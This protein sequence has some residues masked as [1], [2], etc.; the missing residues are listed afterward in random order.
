MTG[1][2]LLVLAI[3]GERLVELVVSTRHAA[4]LRGEGGVE[5]GRG[6][7]P[8]MVVLHIALLVGCFVEPTVADRPF[9]PL[10]GWPMVLVVV[11][12]MG[13]RWWCI[14]TLGH[15][16]N[17]RVIV[18]PSLPLVTG[19]PYRFLRHPNYVAVVAEGAAL[20]LI[21]TAWITAIGF[22]VLNAVLLTVRIRVENRALATA[23]A[24]RPASSADARA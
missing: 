8:L 5:Y 6:H 17:T 9:I 14:G 16:W 20:P 13:L 18:A 15:H 4:F 24:G 1:Y 3:A 23:T 21:H 10:L 11:A 19:G 7:Y 22:T 12:A 2:H